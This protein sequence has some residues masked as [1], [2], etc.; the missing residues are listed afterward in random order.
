MT[1][2]RLL[3]VAALMG[4]SAVAWSAAIAQ[5]A[6]APAQQT[7]PATLTQPQLDQLV[8][9]VALYDDP[10][11]T[12][13][14]TAST[15]P[16]EVVEA[17]RWVSNPAN[18]AL[19]GDP[20]TT[21]LA[22]QDWDPSVKALVPFP[23]VLQM[24]DSHLDWTESLGE[25]FLA[26][27]GD[28]MDAVQ[29]LRHQAETAG[30]LKSGPQETVASDGDDVTI[31]SP[32]SDMIYVPDYNPWCAYGTWPDPVY[33]PYYYEP[34]PGTCGPSEGLIGW[35]AGI[36]LPFPYW[37]WGGFDWRNHHVRIDRGHYGYYNPGHEPSGN[38]WHHDPGHREGVPYRDPRNAQQ[39]RPLQDRQSFRGYEGR[40]GEPSDTPR[41]EPPAFGGYGSGAMT[42]SQ[43]ERGQG[44]R[45]GF[46]GHGSFGGGGHG[47]GGHR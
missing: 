18:A 45:G 20:L 3:A 2:L 11:L 43:S 44:S 40:V 21:A 15:Y 12:D 47:G 27:Q 7:A 13:V 10:L 39:F 38:V 4:S 35:D 34:W 36:Y 31:S 6:P 29:R 24:M 46:G 33:A 1:S 22:D 14:L 30:T 16:L 8:A 32:P 37:D 25:A 41:A 19:K 23:T 9:P 28:V 26:Q 42:R 5:D 17:H